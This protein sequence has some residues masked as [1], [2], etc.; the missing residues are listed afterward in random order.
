MRKKKIDFLEIQILKKRHQK[1]ILEQ[2]LKI[3][4]SFSEITDNLTGV[5]LL[6]KVRDNLFSGS[7]FAFKLGFMAVNMLRK[8]MNQNKKKS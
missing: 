3:K 8:R 1:R 7:G 5:A 2:E 6:N 4:S